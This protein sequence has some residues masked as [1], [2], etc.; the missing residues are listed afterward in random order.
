MEIEIDWR[1]AYQMAARRNVWLAPEIHDDV[2]ATDIELEPTDCDEEDFALDQEKSLIAAVSGKNV[3]IISTM[4]GTVESVLSLPDG[5]LGGARSVCFGDRG[6]IY[7]TFMGPSQGLYAGR[8]GEVSLKKIGDDHL[9]P[10]LL[11]ADPSRRLL[12]VAH[13]RGLIVYRTVEN[14]GDIESV[15]HKY[16]WAD[17]VTCI[18][19]SDTYFGCGARSCCRS[20]VCIDT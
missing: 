17:A 1:A 5:E 12:F 7:A 11:H 20:A 6:V 4:S 8:I 3:Y 14:G 19:Q 13:S 9:E 18:C 16:T 10:T 15:V 2:I